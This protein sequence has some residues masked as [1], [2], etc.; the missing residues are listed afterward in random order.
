MSKKFF[1][2]LAVLTVLALALAA[3]GGQ[4][5]AE[6]AQQQ[7]TQPPAEQPTK[8]PAPTATEAQ[9]AAG[10]GDPARGEALFNQDTIGSA[11]GC[12]TCHSLEPGQVIVGPS[13]AGMADDALE[14]APS[15]PEGFLRE[16]IV[17]PNAE[18]A[19]GFQPDIMY[20]NYGKE[21]TEQQINDLV[22][23]L[24]TLK[25]EGTETSEVQG[26][27]VRGG[28][29]YDKWW[30][31][32]G[33]DEPAE[34]HPLWTGEAE[35]P[36]DTW[37]CKSCHGWLYTGEGDY[38]GLLDLRGADP[39]QILAALKGETNPDHDFSTVMDDQDLKDLSL[40]ISQKVFD[41]SEIVDADGKP[42]NGDAAAGETT[43]QVCAACHGPQGMAINFHHD[44]PEPPEYIPTIAHEDVGE[45]LNKAHWGQPGHPEMPAGDMLGFTTQD[46]ANLLAYM[47]QFPV[48]SPLTEGGQMY[49]NW[50]KAA[51]VDAPQG[52]MPLW[53]QADM[54]AVKNEDESP[55]GAET[56]RCSTCHGWDY[57]GEFGFIGIWDAQNKSSEE[58]MAALTGQTNPDHDFSQFL[59]AD[60]LDALV[61][62]IQNGLVDKSQYVNADG[63]FNGDADHG[64][65]M[66]SAVCTR[67]HGSDG[68]EINFHEGTD[69]PPEY[70]GTVAASEALE[71]FNKAGFGQPGEAMP[72]GLNF[73]WTWQ[74][75]ADLAA[76][77]Q[78]LPTGE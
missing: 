28:Q 29:L 27:A 37:R 48:S 44:E 11:P 63:S 58:I 14:D 72:A 60:R 10:P 77:A 42:V 57:Q 19:G 16:T 49:D 56:W 71:F 69:E 38:P 8:A 45:F 64:Q 70:V 12:K 36:G 59:D 26:D 34:V 50:W 9:A 23:F 47:Q 68:M 67:C 15:D 24:M 73:G 55:A 5:A 18:I 21:L 17:D 30:D 51:V 76:Y 7:P 74:D 13:L 43:F 31:V 3:C 65:Q 22:A 20:Q 61:Y 32:T 53:S 35:G 2:V 39:D 75:I 54:A 33:A 4:P 66:Y 41:A 6:P 1:I 25:G 62:F 52:E 78:T 40:F 46:Y